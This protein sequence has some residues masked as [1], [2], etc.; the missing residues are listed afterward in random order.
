MDAA[1]GC[2]EISVVLISRCQR[3]I[4]A[5]GKLFFRNVQDMRASTQEMARVI[6]GVEANKVAVENPLEEISPN[7]QDSVYL[8]A[9]ERCM[10]EETNLDILFPLSS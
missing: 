10:Q 7:W 2:V 3:S 9:W 6:K 8:T 1:W 4:T 5:L